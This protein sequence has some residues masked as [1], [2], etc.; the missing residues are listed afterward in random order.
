MSCHDTILWKAL[1]IFNTSHRRH[2]L[3]GSTGPATITP[4]ARRPIV[5]V[6]DRTDVILLLR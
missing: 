6:L 1:D 3:T 2:L 4:L 5:L